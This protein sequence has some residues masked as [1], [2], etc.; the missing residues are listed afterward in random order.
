MTGPI[1]AGLCV[2]GPS[3]WYWAVPFIFFMEVRFR[4]ET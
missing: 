3:E 2:G 4:D 1:F